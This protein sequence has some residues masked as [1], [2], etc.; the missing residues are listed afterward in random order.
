[1]SSSRMRKFFSSPA[2]AA[3]FAVTLLLVVT[4]LGFEFHGIWCEHTRVLPCWERICGKPYAPPAPEHLLGTDYQGRSV[5][6]RALAGT[7]PAF[8]VGPWPGSFRYFWG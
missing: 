8:K 6:L 1:M 7:V 2:A 5:L 3:A 4:A